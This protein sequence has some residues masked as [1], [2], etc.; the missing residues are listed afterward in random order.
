MADISHTIDSPTTERHDTCKEGSDRNLNRRRMFVMSTGL[1]AGVILGAA[2]ANAEWARTLSRLKSLSDGDAEIIKRFYEW[3]ELS[4]LER[5]SYARVEELEERAQKEYP[6][7]PTP[8]DTWFMHDTPPRYVCVLIDGR[9]N[10]NDPEMNKRLVCQKRTP[11]RIT[12]LR[13]L[14]EGY[15]THFYIVRDRHGLPDAHLKH[16]GLVEQLGELEEVILRTPTHGSAGV[17]V[18]LLLWHS[19]TPDFDR[20]DWN[21]DFV[22]SSMRDLNRL[23]GGIL[24]MPVDV[25]PET[26]AA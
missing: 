1:A 26:L 4:H 9:I 5:E 7:L 22:I 14:A 6:P 24:E 2:E 12:E 16:E 15:K 3:K 20:T 11:K 25:S 19:H 17:L 8:F 21:C 13:A 10:K 23:S 18:I